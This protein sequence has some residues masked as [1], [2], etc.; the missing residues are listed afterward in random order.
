MKNIEWLIFRT[1]QETNVD[2]DEAAMLMM[3]KIQ[4]LLRLWQ[5][6]PLW[7]WSTHSKPAALHGHICV[8]HFLMHWQKIVRFFLLLVW[9]LF[10]FVFADVVLLAD[11]V[12]FADVVVDVLFGSV[13][14]ITFEFSRQH[15]QIAIIITIIINKKRRKSFIQSWISSTPA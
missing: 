7:H 8:R 6:V 12:V 13:V 11:V 15:K 5:A 14:G 9:L 4:L 10:L 2:D 3:L 1:K